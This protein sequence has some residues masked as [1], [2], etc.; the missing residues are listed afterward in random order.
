MSIPERLYQ[1]SKIL[2]DPRFEGFGIEKRA[3]QLGYDDIVSDMTAGYKIASLSTSWEQPRLSAG[4][5]APVVEG[6]VSPFNDYPCIM[7]RYPAFSQRA[8]DGM[9]DMLIKYGELLPLVSPFSRN[10]YFYNI[11]SISGALDVEY[12]S[13]RWLEEGY[14]AADIHHFEFDGSQ[15]ENAFIFRLRQMP[16]MV[17]VTDS[18]VRRVQELGLNGF[19]F[20]QIWPFPK[21]ESWVEHAKTAK[22]GQVQA[23]AELKSQTLVIF[24]PLAGVKP[25]PEEKKRSKLVQDQLDAQ[26]LVGSVDSLYWGAYEGSEVVDGNLRL[27]ISCPNTDRLYLK[28]SEWLRQLSWLQAPS[29]VKRYGDMYDEESQEAFVQ[30]EWRGG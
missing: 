28:L 27:Y 12:S 15:L 6:R 7:L 19:D 4:W 24:L 17:I 11:T 21:G 29:A 1:L 5:T 30:I 3:S 26:L 13:I 18:F 8:V 20:D 25:T 9:G 16:R 10:Y 23:T 14:K 2:D 22:A